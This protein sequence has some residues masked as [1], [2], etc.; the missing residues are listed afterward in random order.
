MDFEYMNEICSMSII[1]SMN[2][3]TNYIAQCIYHSYVKK[4]DWESD[5]T[6]L[7]VDKEKNQAV[8]VNWRPSLV[9]NE[10]TY[11]G[12]MEASD[13]VGAVCSAFRP[14]PAVCKF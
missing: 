6:L 10:F 9:I 7:R 11:K 2:V 3:S 13:I 12:E 4:G 1:H 14:R 5:N 8:G